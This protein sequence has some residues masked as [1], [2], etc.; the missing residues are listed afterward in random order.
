MKSYKLGFFVLFILCTI[1]KINA[2]RRN[3]IDTIKVFPTTSYDHK[4]TTEALE[5][6]T[7]SIKGKVTLVKKGNIMS[8]NQIVVTLFPVTPYFEEYLALRKKDDPKKLKFVF[9]HP[10]A[11]KNRI[12]VTTN[13]NGEFIFTKMKPGTYYLECYFPWTLNGSY[14]TYTGFSGNTD[15]YKRNYYSQ[16]N[17]TYMHEYVTIKKDGIIKKVFIKNSAFKNGGL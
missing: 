5:E 10:N 2:Q 11:L 1:N 15:Y 17:S 13:E 8:G 12:E 9:I 6:G 14:D 7:S 3:V 16:N 4:V